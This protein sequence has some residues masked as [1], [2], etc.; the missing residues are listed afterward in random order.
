VIVP[1]E[2]REFNVSAPRASSIVASGLCHQPSVFNRYF[3]MLHQQVCRSNNVRVS[4]IPTLQTIE[5]IAIT[6][7]AF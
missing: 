6:L 7:D 4:P 3:C 5:R 2:V 1:L